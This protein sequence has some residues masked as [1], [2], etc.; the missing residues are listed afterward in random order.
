MTELKTVLVDDSRVYRDA[1]R[2]A[3]LGA[4]GIRIVGEAAS[5]EAALA[6]AQ[7]LTPDLMLMD[8]RMPGMGGLEAARQI[9]DTTGVPVAIVTGH[10]NPKYRVAAEEAGACDYIEKRDLRVGVERLAERLLAGGPWRA[11]RDR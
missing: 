11:R 5:G 9:R 2:A 3:L 6:L 8:I 10:V 4:P 7:G 1:A